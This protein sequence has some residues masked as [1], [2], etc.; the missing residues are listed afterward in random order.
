MLKLA[1]DDLATYDPNIKGL[2]DI[3]APLN[4]LNAISVDQLKE[5]LERMRPQ[6]EKARSEMLK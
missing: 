4:E 6:I 3:L 2:V 5:H 1:L